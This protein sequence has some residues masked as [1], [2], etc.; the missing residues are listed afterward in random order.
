MEL[1]NIINA[2]T[3]EYLGQELRDSQEDK[4]RKHKK[5]VEKHER[6]FYE[7]MQSEFLGDFVYLMMDKF[8]DLQTLLDKQDL[9]RFIVLGTYI[10]KDGY[11]KLDNR[12]TYIKKNMLP[13]LL[14][15]TRKTVNKFYNTLI[16]KNL[17]QEDD[18]GIKINLLYFYRGSKR[19]YK[20]LSNKTLKDFTRLFVN[21]T[22]ILYGQTKT[23][24]LPYFTMVYKLISFTNYRHNI[25]CSNPQETD[26]NNIKPYTLEDI[27][28]LTGVVRNDRKK[29]LTYIMS[30]HIGNNVLFI[31]EGKGINILGDIVYV[32][33]RLYY[34]WNNIDDLQ[35]LVNRVDLHRI[36]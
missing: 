11:C 15:T 18:T 20:E 14:N 3:G 32:N 6:S 16:E 4:E 9:A 10:R 23:R 24:D 13:T 36:N 5:A 25:L 26:F 35:K 22:R 30:L 1:V 17:I 29:Y 2:E 28:K 27:L 19:E 31:R 7:V 21:T 33:P 34:R 12:L 8:E